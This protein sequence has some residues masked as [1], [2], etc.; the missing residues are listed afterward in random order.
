MPRPTVTQCPNVSQ[1]PDARVTLKHCTM[2]NNEAS[3]L[4][5]V[6]G[7]SVTAESCDF[8]DNKCN[9]AAA[10]DLRSSIVARACTLR[11]NSANGLRLLY[12]ASGSLLACTVVFN[13][14]QGVEAGEAATR[15]R[16]DDC[17]LTCAPPSDR[18]CRPPC[19]SPTFGMY[20]EERSPIT[21]NLEPLPA[22]NRTCFK[23]QCFVVVAV[24]IR[25]RNP[26]QHQNGAT[27]ECTKHATDRARE[28]NF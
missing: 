10:W 24:H 3:G 7:G 5:V 27:N 4:W 15:L 26:I 20:V 6:A 2:A 13:Q 22:G 23:T 11:R 25:V 14:D 16:I 19:L 1:G 8:Q 9:G 18:M 28:L 21:A 12:G 17:T